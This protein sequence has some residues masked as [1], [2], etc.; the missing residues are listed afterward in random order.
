MQLDADKTLNR[1][2][3]QVPARAG[4]TTHVSIPTGSV[5]ALPPSV[6]RTI[7]FPTDVL[8]EAFLY[9]LPPSATVYAIH[10]AIKD[11]MLSWDNDEEEIPSLQTVAA[12]VFQ[13]V[14]TNQ[15]IYCA[16]N[17]SPPYSAVYGMVDSLRACFDSI[18]LQSFADLMGQNGS[19]AV[20][21]MFLPVVVIRNVLFYVSEA[22]L[23]FGRRRRRLAQK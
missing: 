18:I 13:M 6:L 3:F 15:L 10:K 17:P 2:D 11:V 9:L 20:E 5:D 21:R 22:P 8:V 1:T 7:Q 4:F 14:L 12:T 23:R 16:P 19:E